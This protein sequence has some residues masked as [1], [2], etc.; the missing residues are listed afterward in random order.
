MKVEPEVI[1]HRHCGESGAIGCALEA[2]RLWAEQGHT[3]GFIGLAHVPQIH[4]RT[5]HSED[6]RCHFCKN[7]CV[8]TFIDVHTG[9]AARVYPIRNR[10]CSW[11]LS[12]TRR[13]TP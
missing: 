4:Y 9:G 6:T 3:T 11:R 1:V 12:L 5:T 7:Q 10:L 13:H 8:R 2:H